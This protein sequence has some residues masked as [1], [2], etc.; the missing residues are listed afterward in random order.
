MKLGHHIKLATA[1][2]FFSSRG[3][4][5]LCQGAPEVGTQ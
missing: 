2:V 1:N 4:L 5:A 3:D